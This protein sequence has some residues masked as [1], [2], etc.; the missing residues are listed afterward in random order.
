MLINQILPIVFPPG[1]GG[2][3]FYQLLTLHSDF[4]PTSKEQSMKKLFLDKSLNDTVSREKTNLTKRFDRWQSHERHDFYL[5]QLPFCSN[6]GHKME[7]CI[8]D[9]EPI[10]NTWLTRFPQGDMFYVKKVNKPNYIYGLVMHH[11]NQFKSLDAFRYW[12]WFDNFDKWVLLGKRKLDNHL[13]PIVDEAFYK[14]WEVPSHQKVI[15]VNVDN[16]YSNWDYAQ[17]IIKTVSEK[18]NRHFSEKHLYHMNDLWKYYINL[19][20]LID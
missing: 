10:T 12:I 16:F 17:D 19:H 3:F 7:Y 1:A 2:R 15:K 14:K 20:Q 13:R 5:E 11:H 18:L 9:Q 4:M 8:E 6:K